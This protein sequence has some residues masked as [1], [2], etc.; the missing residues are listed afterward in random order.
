MLISRLLI[1]GL[2]VLWILPLLLIG[3]AFGADAASVPVP[4]SA[5]ADPG[6]STA[7]YRMSMLKEGL[8]LHLRGEHAASARTYSRL[9]EVMPDDPDGLHLLGLSLYSQGVTLRGVSERDGDS[10][11]KQDRPMAYYCLSQSS[12]DRLVRSAISLAKSKKSEFFMRSN[13]GE[14][15]RAN[16]DLEEAET[17]LRMVMEEQE[18]AGVRDHQASF[19]LAITLVDIIRQNDSSRRHRLVSDRIDSHSENLSKDVSEINP[20]EWLKR[21]EAEYLLKLDLSSHPDNRR[22]MLDLVALLKSNWDLDPHMERNRGEEREQTH[23][24]ESIGGGSGTFYKG[25][26][27]RYGNDV[28]QEDKGQQGKPG[29][30]EEA[31]VWLNRALLLDP[32]DASVA[33]EVAV[34]LHRLGRTEEARDRLEE[35]LEMEG[36]QHGTT[37]DFARS[38][39]AALKQESGDIPGAVEGYREVLA[40]SPENCIALNNLGV[41]LLALGQQDE[42]LSMLEK[43]F[44]L[45]PFEPD[46]LVNLGIHWQ[47]DGD[48]DRARSAERLRRNDGLPVRRAIMLPP[49]MVGEREIA[50]EIEQLERA[51]DGLIARD[52]PPLSMSDPARGV[53]RVHFYLVYRGG[54]YRLIQQKI[55]RMYT[56]ASPTLLGVTPNLQKE[57]S[58]GPYRHIDLAGDS[59]TASTT[60]TVRTP[61]EG[62][63]FAG[64]STDTSTDTLSDASTGVPSKAPLDSSTEVSPL[65]VGFVSKFFGDEASAHEPHGILLEGVVRYLP[66]RL[67]R[68]IVC[69]IY[70]PGKRLS[71]SLADAADEVI[72]LPMKLDVARTMLGGLRLDVLVFA[73]MNC[74]PI[75][76]FLG[77]SRLARVQAVFWGNPITTGN[78]S[79]DYFVSAEAMEGQHRTALS[80]QDE[81]YSEQV[82]LLGGQGIWYARPM[83][84]DLPS[85]MSDPTSREAEET[86]VALRRKLKSRLGVEE[87][88]LIFMC[89]QSLFKLKPDFDLVLR[90]ILL[91]FNNNQ[92]DDQMPNGEQGNKKKAYLVLTEGRRKLWTEAF[93]RR[94]NN[95][96]PEVLPQVKM[97]PRMSA[98]KEFRTFLAAADV[99]LHPF[100]FGGSK[101]AADGLALGVP[102]VAMEGDAL[103]G[104]MAF[105]LYKT[106]GLERPGDEGCC[107]ARSRDSYVELAVRLGRDAEYR[108]WAGNLIGQRSSALWERRDVL[109][110]WARFLSRAA[111]RSSPTAEEVN[112]E[113]GADLPLPPP[114]SFVRRHNNTHNNNSNSTTTRNEENHNKIRK[115]FISRLPMDRW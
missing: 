113:Y 98:G 94:L 100:P 23:R 42:G 108:R 39:L 20:D 58:T 83:A 32:S 93:S 17:T 109:L 92:N 63:G 72:Q 18:T 21:S 90:D 12:Y 115:I 37:R 69:P 25:D 64:G 62:D 4:G 46:V 54:N 10:Q 97:L 112:L 89:P 30:G 43:S 86:K 15:L 24:D 96:V 53:E 7:E 14:I 36:G 13:L 19:N 102:V 52:D 56:R 8:G 101:T 74:E 1:I 87:D 27:H 16:G 68:V 34:A 70:A 55:A 73:D 40:E 60:T 61:K 3:G 29:W 110:E 111:G 5:S 51:V 77:Y 41:A 38:N 22:S 57:D 75:S 26:N 49:I 45:D 33:L 85:G 9:L 48:L 99:I 106:M 47:E 88:S 50:Q 95:S 114:K 107:I 79:I 81:P 44:E 78:P 105:S 71:P 91:A 67:F 104:R 35:V 11:G 80:D 6:P 31:L 84:H 82:V 103:P 66:R 65:R 2:G 76:H 28:A 59:S